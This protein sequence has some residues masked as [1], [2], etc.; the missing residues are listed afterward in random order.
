ME[1][2]A[3]GGAVGVGAKQEAV[4]QRLREQVGP[5]LQDAILGVPLGSAG[6]LAALIDGS[7]M[8]TRLAHRVKLWSVVEARYLSSGRVEI[9]GAIDLQEFLRPWLIDNATT[10]PKHPAATSHTGVVVDV[11]GLG[12][13]ACFR[14]TI[15]DDEG[16]TLYDGSIW[17]GAVLETAPVIYVSDASD[18]AA[19]RAGDTPLF[20]KGTSA[21]GCSVDLDS[22]A[23]EA[24]RPFADSMAIGQGTVVVVIEKE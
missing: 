18:T 11:R 6:N 24:F 7:S 9:M 17:P 2:W 3:G 22:S 4:E 15:R 16:K 12:M 20:V 5:A 1:R 21:S 8:G 13:H 10:P 14:P 23:S 19:L